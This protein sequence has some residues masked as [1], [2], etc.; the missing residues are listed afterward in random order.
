MSQAHQNYAY[1]LQIIKYSLRDSLVKV[2]NIES[3][4]RVVINRI[5]MGLKI[6]IVQTIIGTNAQQNTRNIGTTKTK[7][8]CGRS[9]NS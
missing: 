2:T 4:I 6:G 9:R 8:H 3:S 7:Q 1:E 5:F